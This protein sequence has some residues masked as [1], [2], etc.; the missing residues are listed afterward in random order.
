[1][2]KITKR[3][4]DAA[5]PK[6]VRYIVWDAEI[7][8]FG[9]LVLPTGVKSYLFKYRTPEGRQRRATIGKHGDWTP[10]E[11]RQKADEWRRKVNT[12]GD[13]LDERAAARNALTVND[14]LDRYFES[15]KFAEKAASTQ[16]IDKGR[17]D[18][19]LKPLLGKRVIEKMTAEDVRRAF[20]AI[21]DGKTVRTIKTGKKRGVAKVRGGEGTARMA[22]RLLRAVFSWGLSERLIASN[23]ATGVA[24]GADGERDTVLEGADDY[25][26]LFR[27]L[28]KMETEKRIRGPA[29]GAI[30]VIALTGARRGEIAGLRWRHVDL[31]TGRIVIPP[32]SHKTGRKTGKPRIIALPST[33]QEIV[34]RQQE[35]G[36][37]DFVFQPA[38]GDG[39][40]NLSRPWEKIRKEA[41]LPDRIGLHGLRHSLATLLAMGG[42][43]ASEIMAALGHRQLATSQRYVHWAENARAA[44]AEKAAAPVLAGLAASISGNAADVVKLPTK[45]G[46]V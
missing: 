17:A 34:A 24:I 30:R 16:A 13:P 21:R 8:G 27:T 3:T 29:A 37:D 32:A 6:A 23:P 10:D 43:Q 2:P 12:G 4:V 1:M 25:A 19:H 35:G 39:P 22:I 31:K 5:K 41:E 15:G 44:L 18:H 7:M 26:R 45:K 38:S 14:L 33:A 46:A 40:V 9:L 11:A 28:A 20:I 36:P 42:A